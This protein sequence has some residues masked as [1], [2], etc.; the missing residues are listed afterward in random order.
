MS[1][2]HYLFLMALLLLGCAQQPDVRTTRHQ[3]DDL[4]DQD[5]DGV[6][7]QRDLCAD[8]PEGVLVDSQGCADWH[9]IQSLNVVSF[10]FDMDKSDI[11]SEHQTPLKELLGLLES[12]PESK[13]ILIGDTSPEATLDYNREL[14][15]RRTHV[16][17]TL[18]VQNGVDP[19]RI[20]EQEF[21][22]ITSLTSQL[23]ERH[24]RTIAVVEESTMSVKPSWTIFSSDSVLNPGSAVEVKNEN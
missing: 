24:R 4:S 7:N 6:I 15:K 2:F 20:E 18:L 9:T 5:K 23:K 14:A 10:F 17:K 21:T 19:Q 16:I 12:N 3:L 22:Q 8:T 11:K 13:A 1:K